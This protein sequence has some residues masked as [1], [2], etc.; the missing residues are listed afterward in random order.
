MSKEK[1]TLPGVSTT[2]NQPGRN[3]PIP[4]VSGTIMT[5]PNQRASIEARLFWD[6][7]QYFVQVWSTTMG[8]G[9]QS[10][11]SGRESVVQHLFDLTR[12]FLERH[13]VNTIQAMNL[14][15][16]NILGL[17]GKMDQFTGDQQRLMAEL[18]TPTLIQ[19][20]PKEKK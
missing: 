18:G 7:Q 19:L 17:V 5:I 14:V 3:D 13:N 2:L 11:V 10:Y 16:N 9:L 20:D 8:Q 6:G 12:P 4:T 1:F 15:K